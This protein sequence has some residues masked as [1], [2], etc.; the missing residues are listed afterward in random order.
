MYPN[1]LRRYL[2]SLID[3]ILLIVLIGVIA[4]S[5]F[6]VPIEERW[7][8]LPLIALV[9]IYEPL[10]TSYLCTLGQ[11][12]MRFRVRDAKTG[13]RISLWRAY[14]RFLVKGV[15]GIIS[16]LTLPARVDRRA[17]HDLAAGTLVIESSNAGC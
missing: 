4:R 3:V 1:L 14:I 9:L 13:R 17:I 15:L 8:A 12:T 2:G 10:F 11:A 7:D 6:Y 16:F 5:A